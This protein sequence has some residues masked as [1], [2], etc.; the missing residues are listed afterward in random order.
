VS[1]ALARQRPIAVRT[2]AD[3][4]LVEAEA[5]RIG[6][7]VLVWIWGGERPHI[8]AVAAA[9]ARPSLSDPGRR[10]AT[11]SVLAYPGHKEDVVVKAVAESLAARLDTN[12]V[13]A[14]GIHWD[15]LPPD[16][17]AQVVER[18]REI[19]GLLARALAGE[20]NA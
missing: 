5:V 14:A 9:A 16:G 12:V 6:P 18:C 15:D 11:A 17:V 2:A 8:G 19:G 4:W 13:V 7:D 10:S 3:T 1:E 20:G